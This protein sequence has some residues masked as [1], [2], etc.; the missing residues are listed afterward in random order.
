MFSLQ[1]K[2]LFGFLVLVV[3]SVFTYALLDQ[4]HDRL[5]AAVDDMERLYG[6][7]ESMT[8]VNTSVAHAILHIND[9]YFSRRENL[10]METL[11]LDSEAIQTGLQNLVSAF[12]VLAGAIS[13]LRSK[14][15]ELGA[16][17]ERAI[18]IELRSS[19]HV[20]VA[21]LDMIARELRTR[22]NAYRGNYLSAY[23]GMRR[24]VVTM[25][26]GAILAFGTMIAI[27]LT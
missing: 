13:R 21:E 9:A 7:E 23:D 15:R 17:P 16:Q 8:K 19:V 25:G 3:F 26:G 24:I 20:L 2:G 27:F 4:Q 1:A 10:P 6:I 14:T 5:Q 18:L 22:K 11:M 12:P